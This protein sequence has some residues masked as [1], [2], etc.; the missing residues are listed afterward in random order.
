MA[1]TEQVF[2]RSVQHLL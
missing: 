2:F 1:F